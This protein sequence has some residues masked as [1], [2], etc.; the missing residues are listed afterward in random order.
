MARHEPQFA[1]WLSTIIDIDSVKWLQNELISKLFFGNVALRNIKRAT[2]QT[3]LQAFNKDI[4]TLLH[5]LNMQF[6]IYFQF[7]RSQMLFM[8]ARGV[9]YEKLLKYIRMEKDV[10]KF[11]SPPISANGWK[12]DKTIH[13]KSPHRTE[14]IN[15]FR[16]ETARERERE[17]IEVKMFVEVKWL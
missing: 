17:E 16:V 3:Q 11:I 9:K 7:V 8:C 13:I 2:K 14:A 4:Q 10:C 12:Q 5:T 15:Y 6:S 1:L